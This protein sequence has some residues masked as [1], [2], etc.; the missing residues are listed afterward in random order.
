MILLGF[1]GVKV[2]IYVWFFYIIG[3]NFHHNDLQRPFFR[4]ATTIFPCKKGWS[5]RRKPKSRMKA[6][7]RF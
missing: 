6:K 4:L 3:Y 5:L 7:T 2:M 1:Y